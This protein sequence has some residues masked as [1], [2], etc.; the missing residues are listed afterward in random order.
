MLLDPV[1][2]TAGLT[3]ATARTAADVLP[4]VAAMTLRSRTTLPEV[5]V[6]PTAETLGFTADP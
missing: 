3:W 2:D 5:V 6:E 4:E 1:T